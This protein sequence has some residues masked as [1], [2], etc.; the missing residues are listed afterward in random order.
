MDTTT[1]WW[2]AAALLVGAELLTGTF[3]L[4]MLS[5][6]AVAAALVAHTGLAPSAQIVTA[7]VVGTLAVVLWF[8]VRS[9]RKT[10]STNRNATRNKLDIGGVVHVEQWAGDGTAHVLYRGAP[11]TAIAADIRQTPRSGR[12]TVIDIV[13][14]QLVLDPLDGP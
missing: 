8:F 6:G 5:L 12:H 10:V 2:I 14:N 13:N 4:L 3:F 11:W 9:R 1:L 7:A